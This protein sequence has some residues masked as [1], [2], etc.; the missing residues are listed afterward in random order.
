MCCTENIMCCLT[1]SNLITETVPS[2]HHQPLKPMAPPVMQPL[3]TLFFQSDFPR[4]C[5]VTNHS[6]QGNME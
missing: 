4:Y 1:K 6:Q 5:G 2:R 3:I